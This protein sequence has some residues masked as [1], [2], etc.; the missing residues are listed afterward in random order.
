MNDA[1]EDGIGDKRFW[2]VAN[3]QTGGFKHRKIVRAIAN[4]DSVANIDI[5]FLGI[6]VEIRPIW[7]L[8]RE[9]ARS[10]CP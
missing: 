6:L 5:L 3:A 10:H 2:L 4:S 8:Y 9:S 7:R 1:I